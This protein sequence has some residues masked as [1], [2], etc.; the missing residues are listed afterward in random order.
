MAR[1]GD[2]ARAELARRGKAYRARM[3]GYLAG[4]RV[5]QVKDLWVEAGIDPDYY[6]DN[7]YMEAH[8]A[9][10]LLDIG[11]RAV[12][13]PAMSGALGVLILVRKAVA[14]GRGRG[15]SPP[16]ALSRGRRPANGV[17]R[18]PRPAGDG[19]GGHYRKGER[20]WPDLMTLP[21]A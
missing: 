5:V 11:Y 17:A 2:P 19:T 20:P 1:S 15:T 21:S 16:A 14:G 18:R 7:V 9:E 3:M 4:R 6:G 8:H 12:V 13:V 10:R